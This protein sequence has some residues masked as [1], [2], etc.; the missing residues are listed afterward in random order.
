MA[1]AHTTSYQHFISKISMVRA[2]FE[3][4]KL[5]GR[6]TFR[7][8]DGRPDGRS[9][10]VSGSVSGPGDSQA[11]PMRA[12]KREPPTPSPQ[13]RSACH[14]SGPAAPS[15]DPCSA[16]PRDPLRSCPQLRSRQP[17]PIQLRVGPAGASPMR[18]RKPQFRSARHLSSPTRSL[19]PGENPKPYCLGDRRRRI[20]R[21]MRILTITTM[22]IIISGNFLFREP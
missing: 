6:L 22:R 10:S 20:T 9:L 3:E 13:L 7:T 14:L 21:I 11:P 15:S 1:V 19:F 17:T 8:W 16:W 18:P 4:Q 5:W 2:Y 12:R